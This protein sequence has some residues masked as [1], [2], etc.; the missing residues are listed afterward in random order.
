MASL[1]YIKNKKEI[2]KKRKN[3]KRLSWEKRAD[4]PKRITRVTVTSSCF[5]AHHQRCKGNRGLCKCSCHDKYD[6]Y[7][8]FEEIV[9]TLSQE[10]RKILLKSYL[11]KYK[12][13][14][15]KRN[16]KG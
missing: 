7:Q 9:S 8:T 2:N 12:I 6:K 15:K 10:D 3:Y 5:S 13:L 14:S 4:N 1:Y 16:R 11:N